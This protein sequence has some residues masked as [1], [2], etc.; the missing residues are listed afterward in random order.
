MTRATRNLAAAVKSGRMKE[1]EV[2]TNE[3]INEG[4]YFQTSGIV[5]LKEGY[6]KTI[7]IFSAMPFT[8]NTGHC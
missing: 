1:S 4:N 2:K 6:E 5:P 3:T 7:E 8:D